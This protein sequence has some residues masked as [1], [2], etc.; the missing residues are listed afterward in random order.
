MRAPL[1]A[2]GIAMLTAA[3]GGS[4]MADSQTN[5]AAGLTEISAPAQPLKDPVT[6]R[7]QQAPKSKMSMILC[8]R[9]SEW[10]RRTEE[11]REMLERLEARNSR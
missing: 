8:A 1:I 11:D 4:A 9:R 3:F 2:F 7:M 6:C 10:A 5:M